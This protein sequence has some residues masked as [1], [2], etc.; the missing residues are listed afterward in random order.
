M[1]SLVYIVFCFFIFSW[2]SVCD[3][4]RANQH[5]LERG[6]GFCILL[7]QPS[8]NIR[9]WSSNGPNYKKVFSSLYSIG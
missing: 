3:Q 5:Y 1:L 4:H 2:E 6:Q 7:D 8:L 9:P